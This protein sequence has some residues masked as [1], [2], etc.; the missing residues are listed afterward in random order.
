M[1]SQ[2]RITL[3]QVRNLM[4]L[5]TAV[6][7]SDFTGSCFHASLWAG[8]P[9]CFWRCF[10]FDRIRY[11]LCRK[12]ARHSDCYLTRTMEEVWIFAVQVPQFTFAWIILHLKQIC[13]SKAKS[14]WLFVA[15]IMHSLRVRMV[16]CLFWP[17]GSGINTTCSCDHQRIRFLCLRVEVGVRRRKCVVVLGLFSMYVHQTSYY[18]QDKSIFL[19]N[20][21]RIR[22]FCVLGMCQVK[23]IAGNLSNITAISCDSI[24]PNWCG[25]STKC[26]LD[27]FEQYG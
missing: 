14:S 2:P 18:T 8:G 6:A 23:S 12:N 27:I 24:D 16:L 22:I 4:S 11:H 7:E 5:H 26:S 10:Q 25:I 1:S 19:V 20:R 21:C 3:S 9:C 17:V 13:R 15:L